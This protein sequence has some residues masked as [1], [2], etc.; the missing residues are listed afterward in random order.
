MDN[1]RSSDLPK[2]PLNPIMIAETLQY[3][4][5]SPNFLTN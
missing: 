4:S 3:K 2:R 1:G 5:F